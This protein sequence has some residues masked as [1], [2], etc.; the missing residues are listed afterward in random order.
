M[1]IVNAI[2]LLSGLS[3]FLFGM[4]L[5]GE[6]LQKVAGSKLEMILEKLTSTTLRG[7]LLGTLVTAVIQSS[8]ATTVMVVGFV[9]SGIMQLSNAIGI[10]MGANIGT[11]A[12]G[13]ILTL[14]GAEGSG[15]FSATTMFA[16]VAFIGII[17]YFFCKKNLQKNIGLIMLAFSVLM[18]G[19]E[20][21]KE[22]MEPLKESP[23]FINFISTASNPLI[24]MAVGIVVTAIIQSCSASI[25]ILQALSIT[26]II[27]YE[28]AV[29]MVIGMCIG[30]CAPVLLSAIGANVNGKR[31]ALVYL[32]FNISGAIVIM[33]PFYILHAIIGFG[34]MST[35]ASSMGIAIVNT[36]YKVSAT[37]I[38]GFF[39][40]V[41]EKIAVTLVKDKNTDDD[42]DMDNLTLDT[43]LLD[44]PA[45]ALE[46]CGIA[47]N[48]MSSAAFKNLSK[49]INLIN[50]FDQIKYDKIILREN[51]VDRLEDRLGSYLVKLNSK[52]LTDRETLTSAMYL[53]CLSNIE[54]ISDHAVNIA[55]LAEELSE[56]KKHF[57]SQANE[58]L[59]ICL[60]AVSEITEITKFALAENDL[61]KATL[62]EPLE[63]V[64]DTITEG[65]KIRHIKR[66]QSGDCT[67]EL[68]FVYNDCI[69]NLERVS[70]HCSN[71][72]F[73]IMEASNTDLQSHSYANSLGKRLKEEYQQNV[74]KYAEKYLSRFAELD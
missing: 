36:L 59:D 39:A 15:I 20:T 50:D 3:F 60:E 7:I 19:M 66:I 69:N 6:G 68:G 61:A 52:E 56:K 70:D 73:T 51:K 30:A 17:L 27:S 43:R 33:I 22:A 35:T 49:S 41:I 74:K 11:T 28:V 45:I 38:L 42:E 25:G 21:M 31:A 71:I 14:S 23:V 37:V 9:N 2:I 47:I 34:F 8:S 53:K 54:R 5:L 64:I 26:G 12:T 29:P 46:Q 10:I 67:L 65:L 40:K 58:E 72:A 55:E 63:S 57:S 44:Y 16:L 48:Q 4:N 18:S 62:V 32:I 24:A 13:W 1:S